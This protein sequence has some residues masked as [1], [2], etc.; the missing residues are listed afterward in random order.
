MGY[1]TASETVRSVP[2]CEQCGKH[3][4]PESMW[5]LPPVQGPRAVQAFQALNYKEIAQLPQCSMFDNFISVEV[6]SCTC[7]SKSIL[8]LVGHGVEL[9]EE[10]GDEP[11]IQSPVRM[12]SR[13]LTPEQLSQ[14][15]A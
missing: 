14:I 3:M 15:K 10:D 12:F 2:F 9:P 4:E 8:E 1:H 11:T 5:C 6:W 13:P 7:D